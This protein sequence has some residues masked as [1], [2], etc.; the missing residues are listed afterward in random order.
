MLCSCCGWWKGMYR[1]E[2]KSSSE[3]IKPVALSIVELHLVEGI[4]QLVSKS[5]SR[6][7]NWIGKFL[8]GFRVNLKTFLR[9]AIP[10]QCCKTVVLEM[11]G[12]FWGDIFGQNTPNLHDP[13]YTVLLYCMMTTGSISLVNRYFVT[14]VQLFC[15]H[16]QYCK[17]QTKV[18]VLKFTSTHSILSA[19][20]VIVVIHVTLGLP[21][22]VWASIEWIYTKIKF[23]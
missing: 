18:P 17:V 14:F 8:E 11:W 5:I 19:C 21:M 9:L 7:L 3:E 15:A 16:M 23:Y 13:Y 1:D 4:S 2:V 12:W 10:N 22:M 20:N 6:K